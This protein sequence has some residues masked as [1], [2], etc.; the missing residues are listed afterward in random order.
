MRDFTILTLSNVISDLSALKFKEFDIVNC[1]SV[2]FQTLLK[3]SLV[4]QSVIDDLNYYQQNE[5]YDRFAIIH[6]E[7]KKFGSKKVYDIY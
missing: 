4:H 3:N 5:I 6:K 7:K 2:R 1:S